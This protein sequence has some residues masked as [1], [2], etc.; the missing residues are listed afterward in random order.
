ML[1]APPPLLPLATNAIAIAQIAGCR[2]LG[3][4]GLIDMDTIGPGIASKL[5]KALLIATTDAILKTLPVHD[6]YIDLADYSYSFT[7][8]WTYRSLQPN[9]S[10]SAPG[11]WWMAALDAWAK[12]YNLAFGK[13]I[14]L[15]NLESRLAALG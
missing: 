2:Y 3:N 9:T 8:L 1:H 10:M 12:V 6:L 4:I 7:D 11:G 13:H 14:V 5:I 15:D